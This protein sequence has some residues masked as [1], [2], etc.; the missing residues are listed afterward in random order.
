VPPKATAVAGRRAS[1]VERSF[2]RVVRYQHGIGAFVVAQLRAVQVLLAALWVHT[3][4]LGCVYA[5]LWAAAVL[6]GEGGLAEQAGLLRARLVGQARQDG[7]YESDHR[8][9]VDGALVWLG[10]PFQVVDVRG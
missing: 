5:G 3:A 9:D 7:Y 6:S 4:D 8:R 2:E 10:V 1:Q